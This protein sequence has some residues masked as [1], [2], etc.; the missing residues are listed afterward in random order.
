MIRDRS[1]TMRNNEAQIRKIAEQI[2]LNELHEGRGVRINVVGTSGMKVFVTG[3]RDVNH[4]R[5][6]QLN[7]LLEERIPTLI[8]QRL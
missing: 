8:G 3:T 6:I 2:S 4:C 5:H 1:P 7:H